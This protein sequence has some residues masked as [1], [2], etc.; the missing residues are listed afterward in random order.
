MS[1]RGY[2]LA[3]AHE[4]AEWPT[5]ERRADGAQQRRMWVGHRW[6]CD[7]LDDGDPFIRKIDLES[8]GSVIESDSHHHQ[9]R[10]TNHQPRTGNR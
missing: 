6:S 8:F 3:R 4:L 10:T 9:P 7:R 2:A 5:I 1:R